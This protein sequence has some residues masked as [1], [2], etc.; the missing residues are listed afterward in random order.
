MKQTN[1][2]LDWHEMSLTHLINPS[3]YL[4]YAFCVNN[5]VCL[6]VLC[7]SIIQGK[8]EAELHLMSADDAEKSPAGLGRNEPAPLEKPK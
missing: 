5:N 7:L 8:V 3:M 1:T 6:Y 4:F 2:K